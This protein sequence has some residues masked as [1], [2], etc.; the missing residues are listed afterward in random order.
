MEV[1][2]SKSAAKKKLGIREY[3]TQSSQI[4]IV[5]YNGYYWGRKEIQ[6]LLWQ[7][8][9]ITPGKQNVIWGY[10]EKQGQVQMNVNPQ[11]RQRTTDLLGTFSKYNLSLT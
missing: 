1:F 8:Y 11:K 3:F 10:P 6:C 5:H 9:F 7:K 4:C 2:H